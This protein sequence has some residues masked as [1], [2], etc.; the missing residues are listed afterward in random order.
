VFF[1]EY[2]LQ[3]WGRFEVRCGKEAWPP[4]VRGVEYARF[5]PRTTTCRTDLQIKFA[6]DSFRS[7]VLAGLE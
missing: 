3:G 7:S 6:F 4:T 2:A 5:E 1:E